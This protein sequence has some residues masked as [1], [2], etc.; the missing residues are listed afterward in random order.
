MR[1]E[2]TG[3]DVF[4]VTVKPNWPCPGSDDIQCCVTGSTTPPPSNGDVGE[5]ILAK[6]MTQAGQP[7]AVCYPKHQLLAIGY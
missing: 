3:A 1:D 4:L 7:Y 6:A 2:G 5:R